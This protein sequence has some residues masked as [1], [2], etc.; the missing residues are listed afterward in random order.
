MPNAAAAITILEKLLAEVGPA[1][2]PYWVCPNMVLTFAG[3]RGYG[4]GIFWG[5]KNQAAAWQKEV[6]SDLK[7]LK[8]LTDIYMS[9]SG[10]TTSTMGETGASYDLV[11]RKGLDQTLETTSILSF[12]PNSLKDRTPETAMKALCAA[13]VAAQGKGFTEEE[14]GHIAFGVL[15]GYP[16]AAILG[17]TRA[18]RNAQDPFA[19]HTIEADIRGADY[20]ICP[21]PVYD[22]PHHLAG[23]P[24]IQAHEQ[25]WS[26]I[27]KD[28]YTSDFHKK[29]AQD[30]SFKAKLAELDQ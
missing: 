17:S 19:E 24:S 26:K 16:D 13:V 4:D 27:L 12:D 14:V 20:Y 30:A 5:S 23:D 11:L 8:R 28:F 7:I 18:V 21:Q 1:H 10:S 29:L 3:A 22:Y 2:M 9:E 6:D 15:L 25:L